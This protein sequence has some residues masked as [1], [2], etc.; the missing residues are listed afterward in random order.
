MAL[1]LRMI[2]QSGTKL[3]IKNLRK[4]F[5]MLALL[6]DPNATG[7]LLIL[8]GLAVLFIAVPIAIV[9]WVLRI[10][11]IVANQR[12]TI[13]LLEEISDQLADEFDPDPAEAGAESASAD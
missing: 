13:E 12:R 4:G 8:C 11:E 7:G 9:R 6:A 5:P 10:G 1:D 3:S 2:V